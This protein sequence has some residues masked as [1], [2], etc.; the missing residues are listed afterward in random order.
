MPCAQAAYPRGLP[1][2]P[3][4]RVIGDFQ[5]A[6]RPPP[7]RRDAADYPEAHEILRPELQVLGDGRGLRAILLD[8]RRRALR[9]YHREISVGRDP[10]VVR[11]GEGERPARAPLSDD[12]RGYRDAEVRHG[13]EE[14]GY[15]RADAFPLVFGAVARPGG[16]DE[17]ENRKL[18]PLGEFQ[19]PSG[20]AEPRRAVPRAALGGVGY[21]PPL[22]A[23]EAAEHVSVHAA[24]PVAGDVH[25]VLEVSVEV[26]A[27]AGPAE[28]PGPFDRGPCSPGKPRAAERRRQFGGSQRPVTP[29][30]E[31]GD[32]GCQAL[33]QLI[34]LQ[35]QVD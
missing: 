4:N 23:A 22:P 27:R 10:E 3:A 34:R 35:L 19:Q 30:R 15:G 21:G 17:R 9:G 28:T 32:D 16:V 7:R 26:N 25:P 8:D 5:C 13:T 14:L 12:E 33:G 2:P 6:C 24:D 29:G 20:R 18:E 1:Y 11:G 31:Q